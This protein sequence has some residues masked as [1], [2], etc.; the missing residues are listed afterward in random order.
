MFKVS[1][2][3]LIVILMWCAKTYATNRTCSIAK[4]EVK[5]QLLLRR[6]VEESNHT[7]KN[8]ANQEFIEL[9]K[10]TL[11]MEGAFSYPFDSLVNVGKLRST[12]ETLRIFTWNVPQPRGYQK[13]FGFVMVNMN[14]QLKVFELDDSRAEFKSPHEEIGS[15]SKWFGALYYEIVEQ[16]FNNQTYYTLLGVDLNDIFSSKRI[17]EI[18]TLDNGE[19][20]FGLPVFRLNDRVLSRVIYEY[21][22]RATMVLRWDSDH[23]VIVSSHLAPMQPSYAGEFQYYVPDLSYDGFTFANGYWVYNPDIDIRNPSRKRPPRPVE[24]PAENYDPGFL[25]R[26]GNDKR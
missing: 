11:H 20:V 5:L 9:F 12:D 10:Q 1:R 25:Y 13:Y 21:S 7:Q 15:P 4:A 3:V 14:G 17:V 8:L 19:P 23:K 18:L 6:V 2:F 16:S 22:S 26:S 24:P